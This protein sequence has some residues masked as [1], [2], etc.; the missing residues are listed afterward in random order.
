MPAL[1]NVP[2][3]HPGR[4]PHVPVG[5]G[6][7]VSAGRARPRGQASV[8]LHTSELPTPAPAKPPLHVQVDAPAMLALFSWQDG[9]VAE[10][11][12]ALYVL[13]PHAAHGTSPRVCVRTRAQTRERVS[14]ARARRSC[15]SASARRTRAHKRDAGARLRGASRA[16]ARRGRHRAGAARG[17]A[18]AP[19]GLV[20]AER[21]RSTR[22]I[23]RAPTRTAGPG[24]SRA[25][26]CAARTKAVRTVAG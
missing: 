24:V 5:R 20:C 6:E 21:V 8:P 3:E 9:Q 10:P 12:T 17:T 15:P 25:R 18:C 26:L 7:G 16:R 1:L 2:A 11:G 14:H 22:W 23:D 13:T 4:R 19:A